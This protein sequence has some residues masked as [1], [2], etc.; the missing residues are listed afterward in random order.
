MVTIHPFPFVEGPHATYAPADDI[1]LMGGSN[2]EFQ[3][4]K[5][6]LLGRVTAY[7]MEVRTEKSK[8]LT[9]STNN[10]SANISMNGQNLR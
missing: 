4:L 2:G 1:D 3:D 10:I 7:G 9:N 6:R 5:N 8:I